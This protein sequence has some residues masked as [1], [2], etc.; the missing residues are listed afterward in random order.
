MSPLTSPRIGAFLRRGGINGVACIGI[1]LLLAARPGGSLQESLVYSLLIGTLCWLAIDG[2]RI[3]VA[4]G[5]ARRDAKRLA[6]RAG[7]PGW[8]WMSVL[9]VVGA[10]AALT[11]GNLAAEAILGQTGRQD[12]IRGYLFVVLVS[13]TAAA[14][15][16][17]FFHARGRLAAAQA[18]AE[19]AR[20]RPPRRS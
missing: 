3:V 11:L 6:A 2:G 1:A 12:G 4:R 14:V 5:L 19:A 16:T 13:M 9:I 17:G 18:E 7:W 8:G 20:R 15:A 10:S